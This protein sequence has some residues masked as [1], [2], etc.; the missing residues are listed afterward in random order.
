MKISAGKLLFTL[1]VCFKHRIELWWSERFIRELVLKENN[2]ETCFSFPL[3]QWTCIVCRQLPIFICIPWWRSARILFD[4]LENVLMKNLFFLGRQNK[5]EWRWRYFGKTVRKKQ[6]FHQIHSG[7][8]RRERN[9]N[10][11]GCAETA[12]SELG[13]WKSLQSK[14][15]MKEMI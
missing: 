10:W 5:N 3:V 13:N 11:G 7:G 4:E 9:S 6:C 12:E 1:F 8:K 14:F 2:I 15:L